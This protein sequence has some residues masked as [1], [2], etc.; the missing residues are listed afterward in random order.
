MS[1][2]QRSKSKVEEEKMKAYPAGLYFA[3]QQQD[4]SLRFASFGMTMLNVY[5]RV[6]VFCCSTTRFLTPLRF[7]RN[8]KIGWWEDC[9]PPLAGVDRAK[10]ETGVDRTKVNLFT[11]NFSL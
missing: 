6:L 11:F 10:R 9:Y 5:P 1:K 2:E 4:S 7:V 8:D 3:V